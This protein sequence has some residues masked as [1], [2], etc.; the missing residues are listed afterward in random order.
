MWRGEAER[1]EY[2]RLVEGRAEGADEYRRQPLRQPRVHDIMWSRL[3]QFQ[4]RALDRCKGK[5]DA[6]F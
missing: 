3:H 5:G 6:R 1:G 4:H 2:A